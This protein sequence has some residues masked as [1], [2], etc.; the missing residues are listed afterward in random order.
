[1]YH[2]FSTVWTAAAAALLLAVPTGPAWA[3]EPVVGVG[4]H[5][6]DRESVD[7]LGDLGVEH[8]RITLY[9]HTWQGDPGYR[10]EW[11]AG[12]RRLAAAG[13]E[14]LVVV[15]QPADKSYENREATWRAFVGFVAARVRQFP[16]VTAWQLWNEVDSGFQG[17]D[18]F[19][20]HSGLSPRQQGRRYG[21]MLRLAYPAIKE[22]NPR[23]LVVTSGLATTGVEFLRGVNDARGPYDVVGVHAYGFPVR[24]PV[25]EKA[26][27]LRAAF[28]G[29]RLWLTEFGMEEAVV[30][31]DWPRTARQVDEWH[32]ENWRD[33]ILLNER[34]HLYERVYGHVLRQDGD[35]SFDLVRRNG[36]W[37][38]AAEWLRVYLAR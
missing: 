25:R 13:I 36:S 10:E 29:V 14:P 20:Y 11:G 6:T 26:E 19:G 16:E 34:G 27:A 32:L 28:P 21:E 2:D 9:W 17:V 22:A 30:P 12:V 4:T 1:M 3:Q 5:H 35:R 7:L 15:H 37:R 8:A 31:R 18:L 24:N 33:P 38:P 23:A